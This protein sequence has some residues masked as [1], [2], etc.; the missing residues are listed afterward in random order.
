MISIEFTPCVPQDI[1]AIADV[2][3]K[4]SHEVLSNESKRAM[5]PNVYGNV[6]NEQE[7]INRE[8]KAMMEYE[9]DLDNIGDEDEANE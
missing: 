8:K 6:E 1:Q 7:R 4:I 3:S 5:L 9:L 2:I